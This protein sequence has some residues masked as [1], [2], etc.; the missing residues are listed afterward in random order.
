MYALATCIF[1]ILELNAGF[2]S[3]YV[4]YWAKEKQ[5]IDMYI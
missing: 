4:H 3:T 1:Y 2:L 5:G